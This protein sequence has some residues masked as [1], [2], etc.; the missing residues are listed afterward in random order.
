MKKLIT[1]IILFIFITSCTPLNVLN[2]TVPINGYSAH[3]DISYGSNKRN[4]LDVYLP[5]TKDK[6]NHKTVVFFYGGRWRNGVKEDYRFVAQALAKHG[7]I[8]VIPDYRLYPEVKFPGFIEDGAGA[9]K[10][11]HDNINKYGGNSEEICVMGHSAGAYIALMLALDKKYIEKTGIKEF[12]IK[13]AVGLAGPYDFLPI[14]YDDVKEIFG[15]EEKLEITQPINFVS[16]NS[17]PALLMTGEDDDAVFPRN[18]KSLTKKYREKG[19]TV[20]EKIYP[21][22]DHYKIIL[23]LASTV[24]IG[25]S[26]VNDIISFL[27]SYD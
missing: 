2:L 9:V 10:W 11:V 22:T 14:K 20:V 12:P 13:C 24:P 5:S 21:E 18:T 8:I 15:H 23:S 3:R 4:K 26:I 16:K 27:N 6:K 17:P 7:F 1:Y 19:A 25:T